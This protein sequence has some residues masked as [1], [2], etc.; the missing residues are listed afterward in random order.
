[1]ERI[2]VEPLVL[3]WARKSAGFHDISL[4]AKRLGTSE[5]TVSKWE[6]G[7]LQPTIKQ[8]RKIAKTYKRPLAVLL[9]PEPPKEFDALRDFRRIAGSETSTWSPALEGEFRRAVSQ[10][11]V[12]LELQEVA[13]ATLPESVPP[14]SF[15]VSDGS[16]VAAEKLRTVLGI[17]D[18]PRSLWS[19]PRELLNKT[20]TAIEDLGIQVIHTRDVDISEM[21]G[22]SIAEWPF[23]VIAVNGSDWPRPRL[24][25]L[26]HE[27]AHLGLRDGGLC[28]LHEV[29]GRTHTASDDIERFCNK[30]AAAVLMPRADLLADTTVA[31]AGETYQWSLDEL[32]ALSHRYGASAEAVLI[33]LIDL[34]KANWDLYNKRKPELEEIYAERRREEK[35]KRK[36]RE[37][38]PSYYVVKA[39]DLG[40]GYVS[41]V[42]EAYQSRA[43]SS[44]DVTDYLNVRFEQLPKLQEAL[45]R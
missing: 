22:F 16:D 23:P 34:G 6:D 7:S 30:V 40:H 36:E 17:N 9:L 20:V 43:I 3:Q 8:L 25:T 45:R 24:F 2:P 35:Q 42:L 38:G 12:Y 29:T 11:E 44:L 13:P 10:R 28:D 15:K 37:G 31:S 18:W 19:D 27:L 14:F 5:M 21:R 1:M 32:S 26:L 33:R 4:A 41:S 39:R